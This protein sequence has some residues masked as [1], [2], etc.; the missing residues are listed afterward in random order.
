MIFHVMMSDEVV[1]SWALIYREIRQT[2]DQATN[3]NPGFDIRE[4]ATIS[5]DSL[6]A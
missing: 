5:D 4:Y 3:S 6:T 2:F 1:G